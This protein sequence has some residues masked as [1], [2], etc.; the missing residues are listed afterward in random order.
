[1]SSYGPVEDA[2][3]STGALGNALASVEN[4]HPVNRSALLLVVVVSLLVVLGG[5]EGCRY[6]PEAPDGV[7]RCDSGQRCPEGS[8]CYAVREGATVLLVCCRT[9]G[10]TDNPAVTPFQG[11]PPVTADAAEAMDAAAD[12]M[13]SEPLSTDGGDD[14]ADSDGD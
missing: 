6:D 8:L 9:P 5:L 2:L 7:V 10:C 14:V 12:L 1:M 13:S 3:L 11:V 4:R